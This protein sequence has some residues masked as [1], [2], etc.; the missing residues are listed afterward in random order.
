[1]TRFL[2][3]GRVFCLGTFFG[4]NVPNICLTNKPQSRCS[5]DGCNENGFPATFWPNGPRP[6]GIDNEI[7]HRHHQK[8]L[9]SYWHCITL[10]KLISFIPK[11]QYKE[12]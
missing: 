9:V 12:R 2:G 1:M 8:S 5:A 11:S 4:S 3:V 10:K 7:W 6:T